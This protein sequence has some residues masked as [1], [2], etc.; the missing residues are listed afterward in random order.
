MLDF[1]RREFVF[2]LDGKQH[3]V[4]NPTVKQI[5]ELQK[6]MEGEPDLSQTIEFLE[7]L[8]LDKEVAYSMEAWQLQKVVESISGGDEEKK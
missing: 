8:G 3:T 4:K 1:E 5:E 7:K 2:K 6:G